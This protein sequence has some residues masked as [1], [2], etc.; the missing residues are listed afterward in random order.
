MM[1]TCTEKFIDGIVGGLDLAASSKRC[2]GF[3]V[4][5]IN[6]MT[7]EATKCL[8]DDPDIVREVVESRV[9]IL[10]VD[11]PLIEVPVYRAVDKL[12]RIRGYS[13]LPP[14]L[15]PMRKLVER[16]WKLKNTL[17]AL[18]VEIIETHPRSV[19]KSS[20][21]KNIRELLDIIGLKYSNIS[22]E[23]LNRD[24]I[25]SIIAAIVAYCYS[26]KHCIDR[27]EAEDGL[28]YL[29]KPIKNV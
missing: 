5:N 23:K 29:I 17:E 2:S 24:Q 7:L 12:S 15:G 3:A 18:G 8:Y 9:K 11:A 26:A 13:V 28:I 6:T 10:S 16:A 4:I 21:A 20:R 25:D 22:I 19:L 14:T 27:V 1:L